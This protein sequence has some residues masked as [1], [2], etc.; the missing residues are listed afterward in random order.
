MDKIAI[1][2]SVLAMGEEGK[3][4]GLGLLRFA[5]FGLGLLRFADFGLRII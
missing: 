4:F 1:N 3:L 5:D 2:S